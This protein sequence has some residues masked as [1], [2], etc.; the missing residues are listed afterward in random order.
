ML[1]HFLL[2]RF[3]PF[4]PLQHVGDTVVSCR[5]KW[6]VWTEGR[7]TSSSLFILPI[8]SGKICSLGILHLK[9]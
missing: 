2:I 7:A 5:L 9:D 4:V 6:T 3:L 8:L 1:S